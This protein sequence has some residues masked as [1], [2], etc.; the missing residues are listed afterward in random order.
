MQDRQVEIEMDRYRRNVICWFRVVVAGYEFATSPAIIRCHIRVLTTFR[1]LRAC[2]T[3]R[4]A[5]QN[6]GG[7]AG[8]NPKARE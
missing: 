7:R 2:R 5:W 1:Q 8:M 4:T 3:S 6:I